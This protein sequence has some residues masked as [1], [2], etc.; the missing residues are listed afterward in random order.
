M[1]GSGWHIIGKNPK[2]RPDPGERV[3]IC[4]DDA[5]VGEGYLKADGQWYRY[6]DLPPVESWMSG[7]VTAWT[8]MPEP[9][10]KRE[11]EKGKTKQA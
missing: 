4:V 2:D 3:I 1:D 5:Y 10:K 7:K 9:P 8:H 6:D 11:K